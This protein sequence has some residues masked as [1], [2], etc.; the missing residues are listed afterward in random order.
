MLKNFAAG[1]AVQRAALSAA[2]KEDYAE[3]SSLRQPGSAI[4]F[5][6]VRCANCALPN[7][8]I[9]PQPLLR[10]P[11]SAALCCEGANSRLIFR[12]LQHLCHIRIA[13]F[14]ALRVQPIDQQGN[15]GFSP[16]TEE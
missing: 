10:L 15:T 1:F 14:I 8:P 9:D 7:H 2:E 11:C 5:A 4:F 6:S 16:V 13:T 12:R 3:L